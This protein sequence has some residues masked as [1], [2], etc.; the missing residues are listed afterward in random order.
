MIDNNCG[1][2]CKNN[3]QVGAI[4]GSYGEG[5]LCLILHKDAF[6]IVVLKELSAKSVV[7]TNTLV[8]LMN[9]AHELYYSP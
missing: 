2:G 6:F 9:E 1:R 5:F 4:L 3:N 8:T 7:H